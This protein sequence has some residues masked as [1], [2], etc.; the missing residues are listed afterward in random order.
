MMDGWMEG[1]AGG[2]TMDGST[3][4]LNSY[5]RSKVKPQLSKRKAIYFSAERHKSSKRESEPRRRGECAALV[6]DPP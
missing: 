5:I 3:D 1:W 4:K 6:P 2:W